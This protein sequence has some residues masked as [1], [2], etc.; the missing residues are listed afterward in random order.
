MAPACLYALPT[1]SGHAPD[2]SVDGVPEDLLPDLGQGITELL[3]S[4]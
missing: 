4:L 2:Q 3:D 1:K